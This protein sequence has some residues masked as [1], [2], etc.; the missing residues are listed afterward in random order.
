MRV[1]VVER[2]QVDVLALCEARWRTAAVVWTVRGD[3]AR[4]RRDQLD[5]RHDDDVLST[6]TG[7]DARRQ[8]PHE[9]RRLHARQIK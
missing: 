5:P 7:D 2:R 4:P 6:T 9:S 1:I 3:V 8:S